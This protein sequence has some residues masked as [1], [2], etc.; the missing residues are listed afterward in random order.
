MALAT[1]NI[2]YIAVENPIGIMS[3]RFRKPDQIIQPYWFGD[4]F[5]KATCLWLKN[6]S[7]LKPT[8]MVDKGEYVELKSGKRLPNGIQMH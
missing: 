3:K 7:P 5:S 4:P 1:A 6:L 8:N 2:K